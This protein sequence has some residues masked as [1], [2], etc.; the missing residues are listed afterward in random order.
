MYCL[1]GRRAP[2]PHYPDC[3]GCALIGTAYT[4]QLAAKRARVV[5]ALAAYP[6]LAGVEVPA[7]GRLAARLRLPQPGQA[8]RPRA[9][10]A[11][12][13]SASTGPGTHR[14]S[15]SAAVP[16]T[17]RRITA[18]LARRAR[19]GRAR[20]RRRST[21]S[22]AAAAGCATSW[23]APAAWKKTRAAHPGRARPHTG[24]R[25]GAA[26]APAPPARREQRRAEPQPQRRATSSS[27][28]LRRA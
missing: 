1:H 9:A 28:T 8:G 12:C 7:R 10:A 13:C 17:S 6:R 5:A 20:R 16:C 25:G 27:A 2:C 11:G 23:C 4:A 18:V 22:A 19:G 24:G 26:R 15:T 14:W 21:T 3:V